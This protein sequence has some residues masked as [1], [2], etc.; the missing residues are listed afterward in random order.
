MCY[1]IIMNNKITNKETRKLYHVSHIEN[2]KILEPRV[3][4]HGEAYVYATP[5]LVLA[6]LF[7]SAKSL[8]DFDGVYGGKE[9]PYFYEAY[10]GALKRRFE[11]ESCYIYEVDPTDFEE[12]KTTFSSELVSKKTVKILNCTKID[13]LYNHLLKLSKENKFN[14]RHYEETPNYIKMI[15]NH[16]K[17]RLIRF[18][19]LENKNSYSY[20]FC[21]EKFPHIIAELESS[22]I[23]I[24]NN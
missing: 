12:N 10:H 23:N 18:K 20:K 24:V 21:K 7:G 14:Y 17:D 13:D 6:L 1:H 3:S 15:N 11:G 5:Y 8:G 2:L 16:I 19:T 9:I 22:Q 4:T